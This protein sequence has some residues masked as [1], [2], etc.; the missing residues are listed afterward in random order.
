ER[1]DA[2]GLQPRE[3][4]SLVVRGHAGPPY[5]E[6]AREHLQVQGSLTWQQGEQRT[7]RVRLS[8]DNERLVDERRVDPGGVGRAGRR[9][10]LRVE[11][12]SI[13][14]AAGLAQPAGR[15]QPGSFRLRH[16]PTGAWWRRRRRG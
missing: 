15:Q 4:L 3:A 2:A 14:F 13:V 11:G 6:V 10:G 16:G 8:Y 9:P 1:A 5:A 7:A 12:D